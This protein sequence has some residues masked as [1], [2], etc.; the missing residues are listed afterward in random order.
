MFTSK[1]VVE[2]PFF[3]CVFLRRWCLSQPTHSIIWFGEFQSHSSWV[4]AI[5][6]AFKMLFEASKHTSNTLNNLKF[7]AINNERTLE[8]R[9]IFFFRLIIK[10]HSPPTYTHSFVHLFSACVRLNMR[11][12]KL[13][14]SN[15]WKYYAFRTLITFNRYKTSVWRTI[16]TIKKQMKRIRTVVKSM[17]IF[18]LAA[19]STCWYF[20]RCIHFYMCAFLVCECF[21]FPRYA[22]VFVAHRMFYQEPV[23]VDYTVY[24]CHTHTHKHTPCSQT[25]VWREWMKKKNRCTLKH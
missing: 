17:P 5:Q 13:M 15:W 24:S 25:F 3:L 12:A 6:C 2:N 7:L 10:V 4:A 18:A 16:S 22:R 1:T 21:L 9:N 14:R 11:R 23:N 8:L 19:Y 20:R